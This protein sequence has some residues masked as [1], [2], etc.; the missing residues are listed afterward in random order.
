MKLRKQFRV[1]LK[2]KYGTI[3]EVNKAWDTSFW[4][5]TFYDWDEIVL[6]NMLSEHFEPDRTTFQGISLDLPPFQFRREC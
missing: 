5:H 4:G 6:P 1:W 2:E 3:E